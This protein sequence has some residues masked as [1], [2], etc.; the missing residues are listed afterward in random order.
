MSPRRGTVMHGDAAI[1]TIIAAIPS[2]RV[3]HDASMPSERAN[4]AG[5]RTAPMQPITEYSANMH[6]RRTR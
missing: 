3:S 6:A 4:G 2:L 5:G 1:I